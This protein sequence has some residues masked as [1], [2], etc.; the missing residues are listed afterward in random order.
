MANDPHALVAPYALHAL[1][2]EEGRSFEQ[3]LAVC[4]RCREELASLREAAASLAYGAAGP[5]PPPE[6]KE[7]IL[8]QARS[9]RENVASLPGHRRNWTAPLAAAAAIAASVAIGLGVWTATRPSEGDPLAKVLAQPGAKV[10]PMGGR[11]AMVVA[12]NG[13]AALALTLPPAPSGKTYEAWVIQGDKTRPAGIFRGRV[14][15]TVVEI[16]RRVPRGSVI[17]VTLERAG[18]VDQPTQRPLAESEALS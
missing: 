4:E 10:V 13:D 15:T 5:T 14:G 2:D 8:A 16:D 18:G 17:A 6:L 7:R 3:H 11:G 1:G 9:E 12:P